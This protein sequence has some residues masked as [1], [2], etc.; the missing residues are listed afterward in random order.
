[1]QHH[2]SRKALIQQAAKAGSYRE[3]P[4]RGKI[5]ED[6]ITSFL[7]AHQNWGSE[8]RNWPKIL[9]QYLPKAKDEHLTI[10][11]PWYHEGYLV[12]DLTDKPMFQFDELPWTLSSKLEPWRLLAYQ[13][14][15][16]NITL[17]DIRVRMPKEFK[18]KGS[19]GDTLLLN[20]LSVSM[21]ITIT[22]LMN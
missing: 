3:A 21:S 4:T 15:N 17:R 18:S 14:L 2:R 5:F 9:F 8:R 19:Q 22:W 12:L 7:P 20:R 11:K 16:N 6:D 1:M 13:R 10:P